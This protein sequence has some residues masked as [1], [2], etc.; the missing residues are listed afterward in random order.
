MAVFLPVLSV[1]ARPSGPSGM[2][3]CSARRASPR[4]R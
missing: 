4:W 2:P 3:T 1:V